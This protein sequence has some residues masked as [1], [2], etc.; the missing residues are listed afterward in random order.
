MLIWCKIQ[1]STLFFWKLLRTQNNLR[2]QNFH[3]ELLLL[4]FFLLFTLETVWIQFSTKIVYSLTL[5]CLLDYSFCKELYPW[6][7]VYCILA[8][9]CPSII[10]L[11]PRWENLFAVE[12]H[13]YR[14]LM[15][16]GLILYILCNFSQNYKRLS[17]HETEIV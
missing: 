9:D 1:L 13:T 4:A 8:P 10:I 17:F 5:L 15:I 12:T 6:Y 11:L 7:V 14:N 2:F 3:R 16:L